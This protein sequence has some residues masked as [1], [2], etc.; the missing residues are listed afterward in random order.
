MANNSTFRLIEGALELGVNV[1]E[2]T[3]CMPVSGTWA[4]PQQLQGNKH[5]C[6][7][8][9][10]FPSQVY[11]DTVGEASR[12]QQRLSE[13]FPGIECACMHGRYAGGRVY[14]DIH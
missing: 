4:R 1:K 12:H 9:A 3:L 10:M 11:V 5:D 14:T 7:W 6:A 8:V 13:R 2:V